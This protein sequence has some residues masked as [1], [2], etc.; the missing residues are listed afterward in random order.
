MNKSG[1][2]KITHLNLLTIL[3]H[4]VNTGFLIDLTI[5]LIKNEK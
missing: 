5:K 2:T 1:Q 3:L 4:A